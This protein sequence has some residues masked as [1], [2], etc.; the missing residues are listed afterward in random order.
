MRYLSLVIF[1]YLLVNLVYA[2]PDDKWAPAESVGEENVESVSVQSV[3]SAGQFDGIALILGVAA[4]AW[5]YII[6]RD[7]KSKPKRR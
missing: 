2:G 3:E 6:Y 4:F 1:S 7:L 5:V